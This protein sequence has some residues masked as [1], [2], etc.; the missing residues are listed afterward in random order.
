MILTALKVDAVVGDV[1]WALVISLS[2]KL[3]SDKFAQFK[4]YKPRSSRA[5]DDGSV[6][7]TGTSLRVNVKV[8]TVA[9]LSAPDVMLPAA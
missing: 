5:N 1:Q 6:P 4:K 2:V 9:S 7:G 8:I 3:A